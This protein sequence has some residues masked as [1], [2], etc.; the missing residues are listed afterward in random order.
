VAAGAVGGQRWRGGFV[1]SDV[2]DR[3]RDAV[4]L[5][6][7]RGRRPVS[8]C[9]RHLSR[10]ELFIVLSAL[11]V[12]RSHLDGVGSAGAEA[13]RSVDAVAQKLGGDPEAYFFGLEPNH[14]H[15]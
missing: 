13:R 14:Q 5:R 4:V 8:D 2:R 7:V 1:R 11:W 3:G 15:F 12:R 9:E 6:V 10:E